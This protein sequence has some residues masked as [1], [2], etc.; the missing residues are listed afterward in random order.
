M[1]TILKI[2]S[3]CGIILFVTF[4]CENEHEALPRGF[5]VYKTKGD[6]FYNVSVGTNEKGE[7]YHHPAF[8]N[9]RYNSINDGRINI[10][11]DDTIYI[12]R[13]R[14]IDGYIFGGEIGENSI[15][16]DFT[17]KEYI[18][19]EINNNCSGVPSKVL[20]EHILDAD[21]FLELY[22]DQNRPGKYEISDTALINRM[23]RNGE[24]EEYFE[25][26]K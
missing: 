23:I 11:E 13:A 9:P 17:F 10:T 26:I 12:F 1:K 4:S 8:Y 7:L 5:A 18:N 3:I 15:F 22:I 6:Y 16:L 2:L 20:N 25:K 24:L 21:P 19:Y 14:L